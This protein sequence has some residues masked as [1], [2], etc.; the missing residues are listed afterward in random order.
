MMRVAVLGSGPGLGRMAAAALL[1]EMAA[2]TLAS[3]SAVPLNRS[4]SSKPSR[5]ESEVQRL[6]VK[7]TPEQRAWND[8]VDRRKA[9]KAGRRSL[10]E[11]QKS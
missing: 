9:E 6:E 5:K 3:E 4:V 2:S 10:A 1:A 11:I 7:M 8:A